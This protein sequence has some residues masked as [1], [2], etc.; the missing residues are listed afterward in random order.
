MH[1]QDHDTT[2]QLVLVKGIFKKIHQSDFSRIPFLAR[3]SW[4]YFSELCVS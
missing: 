4:S 1:M 3:L 2:F